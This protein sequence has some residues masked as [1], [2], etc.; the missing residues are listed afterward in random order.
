M[1]F[2][3]RTFKATIVEGRFISLLAALGVMS[4]RAALFFSGNVPHVDVSGNGYLWGYIGHLFADPLVSFAAS[5]LSVFLIA[6]IIS[7]VNSRFSLIRTR[8]NLPFVA[9]LFLLSLHPY[10]LVMKGDYI[11]IV[12][13]LLAF[14]PLLESYQ[15][16]DSYLYSFR[17]A[18]LLAV[19]SL[20]QIYALV[21]VPLWWRGERSMRGTQLRSFLS[22]LFGVFLVYVSVFSLYFL[23]DDLQGFVLP[24]LSFAAFSLPDI[25]EYSIVEWGV[26][27][28]IGLFFISNMFFSIKTYTRD[29]VLT[30]SFMQFVV[31]LVVFL[32]L[33]QIVYWTRTVFFLT[34]GIALISYLNAYFYTKTVSK[35]HIYLAYGVLTLML[36][37]YSSHFFPYLPFLQ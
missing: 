18:V 8:S 13:I 12:F 21:L 5:T 32:L 10:F 15:K 24:Y 7:I 3:V 30:L 29:K 20:F 11:S 22:S 23:S 2:V 9:P 1:H 28:L 16:L 19:A 26:V 14:F 35:T 33:L 4:M 34:L 25:P 27:V 6:W 36:L 17:S 31:F 37:F